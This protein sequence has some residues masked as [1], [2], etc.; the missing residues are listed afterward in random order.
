MNHETDQDDLALGGAIAQILRQSEAIDSDTAAR[1]SA[2]RQ[3]ALMLAGKPALAR[4]L[5][6]PAS[7]FAVMALVAIILRPQSQATPSSAVANAHGVEALDLLTDEA[8]PA[9]YRDLEFYQ[10]LEKEQP[11]A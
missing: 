9:F 6:V 10:W 8:S 7:A 5:L 11:H 1:L 2:A 3:Q 4:R